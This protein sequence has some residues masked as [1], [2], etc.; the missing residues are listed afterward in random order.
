MA[1][2]LRSLVAS[3]I[4][5]PR[6]VGT[7]YDYGPNPAVEKFLHAFFFLAFDAALQAEGGCMPALPG[8]DRSK[9]GWLQEAIDS[10]WNAAFGLA[11]TPT[12][13]GF[14]S[15]FLGLAELAPVERQHRPS[16]PAS[17]QYRALR[18]VVGEIAL[19]LHALRCAVIGAATVGSHAFEIA[20]ASTHWVDT[21]WIEHELRARR[22]LI[23]PSGVKSLVNDLEEDESKY[24]TQFSDRAERWIDLAQLSLLYGLDNAD[25]YVVRAADCMI[26]YGWRKD[27]WIFDVLAAVESIHKSGEADVTPWL[28]TL[29]P[30]IDQITTFTDG[31]E[32][33]H[34]PEE[35]IDLV[36]QAKPEWLPGLYAH[37]VAD[38]EYRLAE[39]TLSA[40]LGQLDFSDVTS[41]ALANS[42][43][44]SG[45]LYELEKRHK[46]GDA[47]AFN[48]L[49]KRRAF[50]GI[51][52]TRQKPNEKATKGNRAEDDI[53][54]GGTPPDVRKFGP[55]KLE[56]LLKRIA[57]PKLGYIHRNESLVRWL[58]YWASRNKG[59]IALKSIDDYFDSHD[60]PLKPLRRECRVIPVNLW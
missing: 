44:E 46:A 32:T 1:V 22:L 51:A 4:S 58:K 50:L 37:H 14:E 7:E 24:V 21:I 42:L 60:K 20:R 40:V 34:A 53:S 33:N 12:D 36:A 56:L 30:L 16:E 5:R 15:I 18:A 59:L 39:K 31:D 57:S 29:A 27:V 9:L 35:F 17:A 43:L 45:D 47:Y 8:I 54:R 52:T 13:M 2:G 48:L 38:E 55:D 41:V 25:K 23:D 6:L 11:K 3:L 28:E 19:D 49:R 26:G 10:L